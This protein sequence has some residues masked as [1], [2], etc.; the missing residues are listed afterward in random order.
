MV[1]EEWPSWS[2]ALHALGVT[3]ITTVLPSASQRVVR[4]IK[5][6]VVGNSLME[7]NDWMVSLNS[8]VMVHDVVFVQGSDYFVNEIRSKLDQREEQL[9]VGIVPDGQR[10]RKAGSMVDRSWPDANVLQINHQQAGGVTRWQWK[11]Y[12]SLK[13][14]RLN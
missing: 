5:E 1:S 4:E 10:T 11:V 14:S 2:F 13:L 7:F 12:S 6:T 3:G 9:F 8:Q